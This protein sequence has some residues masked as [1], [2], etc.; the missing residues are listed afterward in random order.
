MK[1]LELNLL[2][3][4]KDM[5]ELENLKEYIKAKAMGCGFKDVV[6]SDHFGNDRLLGTQEGASLA[7]AKK[8][9][10][11]L[12]GRKK[13]VVKQWIVDGL[14]KHHIPSAPDYGIRYTSSRRKCG[15][16]FAVRFQP[17]QETKELEPQLRCITFYNG[18]N[19]KGNGDNDT[20]VNL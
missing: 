8:A 17:N 18:T 14:E 20:V 4:L 3:E 13:A 10:D 7:S 11:D 2:L 5:G 9:I 19:F 16:A 15:F 12:F 6:F 1:L